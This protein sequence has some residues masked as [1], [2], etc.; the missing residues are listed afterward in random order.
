MTMR[1]TSA[2][3]R[4]VTT[5]VVQVQHTSKTV[6]RAEGGAIAGVHEVTWVGSEA[7]I[8]LSA[9]EAVVGEQF[10]AAVNRLAHDLA[11][12]ITPAVIDAWLGRFGCALP[13]PLPGELATDYLAEIRDAQRDGRIEAEVFILPRSFATQIDMEE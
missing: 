1:R 8:P 3:S 2:T 11:E 12:Q 13:E 5:S 4:E 9:V 6:R 10:D 7:A